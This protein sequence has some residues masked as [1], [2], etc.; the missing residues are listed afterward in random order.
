MAPID[1]LPGRKP[2]VIPPSWRP[3]SVQLYSPWLRC[4][5]QIQGF[6]EMFLTVSLLCIA[7]TAVGAWDMI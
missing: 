5:F 3:L 1:A 6:R 7:L 4:L 2:C